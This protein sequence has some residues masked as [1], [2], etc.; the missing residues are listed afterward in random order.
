MSSHTKQMV[1]RLRNLKATNPNIETSCVVSV[2]GQIMASTFPTDIDEARVLEI[3]ATLLSASERL[4]SEMRSGVLNRITIEGSNKLIV[5][6]AVGEDAI[7]AVLARS[8]ADLGRI[9]H[10]MKSTIDDLVRLL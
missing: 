9:F 2:N 3:S 1:D 5:L 7:L 8:E 4:M 10:D 6:A